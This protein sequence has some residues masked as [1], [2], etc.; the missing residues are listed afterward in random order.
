MA[1]TKYGRLY[2]EEDVAKI[3]CSI[4]GMISAPEAVADHIALIDEFPWAQLT[5]PADE[6]LF[7][8]RGQDKAAT[9]G[10]DAYLR[11]CSLMGA[12][13]AHTVAIEHAYNTMMEFV[14]RH[15]DRVKV[16]DA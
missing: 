7:L 12:S 15:P 14:A 16:P 6:P 5:F 10:V 9:T 13:L 8:L 11:E 2:T 3:V 4:T 1:D